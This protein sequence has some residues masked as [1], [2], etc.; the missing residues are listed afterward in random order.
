MKSID[1]TY[2]VAQ[3]LQVNPA[4]HDRRRKSR[5]GQ[6]F[7]LEIPSALVETAPRVEITPERKPSSGGDEGVGEH[8]N[9]VV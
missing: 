3:P 1:R 6:P 9:I 4:N 2:L 7:D 8:V 5:D